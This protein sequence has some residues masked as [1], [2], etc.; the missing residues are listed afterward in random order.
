LL[1]LRKTAR[2]LIIALGF[3]AFLAGPAAAQEKLITVASTT[4]AQD[5]GLFGHLLPIFKQ[6]TGIA[7]NVVS[8]GT[9]QAL[10]LGRRIPRASGP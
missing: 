5:S 4:E 6:K 9:G 1:P 3:A 8:V 2:A 10:D 7:V